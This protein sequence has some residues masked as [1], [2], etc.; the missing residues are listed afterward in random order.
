MM[1]LIPHPVEHPE[2]T[3][4]NRINY[5]AK[6]FNQYPDYP[7]RLNVYPRLNFL[8]FNLGYCVLALAGGFLPS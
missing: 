7:S 1:S 3:R 6:I 8:L 4:F 5:P 2:G